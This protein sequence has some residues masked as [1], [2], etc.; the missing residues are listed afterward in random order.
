MN[1]NVTIIIPVYKDW[2]SLE[3]CISSLQK[4]VDRRHTVL[5]INDLSSE[6][7]KLEK[8]ILASIDGFTNFSYFRNN[9]NIGFL[10]TCNRG[11]YELDETTNDIL[12]L[13][14]DT[15]V[16]EGFLEEMLDI[17]YLHEKHGIVC[18]RSNNATILSIPFNYEGNRNQIIYKSYDYFNTLKNYL[19][20]FTTI[21]AGDGFC[22][23]IRRSLI[24]NFGLFDNIYDKG[25]NGVNDFCSRIN[26]FG[27]SAVMANHAFVYHFASRSF[28][29]E[30]IKRQNEKNEKIL[31]DSYPE[32]SFAVKRYLQQE[33]HPADYFSH[34]ICQVYPKKKI[35]FSLFNLSGGYDGTS[36]YGLSLLE[37]FLKLF[38]NKY[39]IKILINRRGAI[40]HGLDKLYSDILYYIEDFANSNEIFDLAIA[41]SQFF[42]INHLILLNRHALY[43]IFSLQDII[44]WRCNYLKDNKLD[45]ILMYS[46]IYSDGIIAISKFSKNDLLCYLENHRFFKNISIPIK[47]IYH[48]TKRKKELHGLKEEESKIIEDLAGERFIFLIGNRE[49]HKSIEVA[50][51]YL[52]DIP[53]KIVVLGINKNQLAKNILHDLPDNIMCLE[54]GKLSEDLVDF[55]YS[56]CDLI[57][58]PSQ[59][60]G[61]GLPII[62]A[63]LKK[64]KIVVFDN[65]INNELIERNIDFKDNIIKFKYYQDLKL[66][67]N[68]II[69]QSFIFESA[70][71]NFR[72][73]DDVAQETEQF[74]ADIIDRGVNIEKLEQRWIFFNYLQNIHDECHKRCWFGRQFFWTPNRIT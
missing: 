13:N 64:K 29:P 71:D 11:V 30:E 33:I 22:M 50:I 34:I 2:A 7:E 10:K 8:N 57:I 52:L 24:N 61:F 18:P 14:S 15:E 44:G 4:F 41:P 19:P 73:W 27:Y 66:I 45:F 5:I 59:Y 46:F 39:E 35:L 53:I 74:L 70:S 37:S 21:P 55:L 6:A 47:T 63:L 72:T 38:D 40:F 1:T 9:Q 20:R 3:K 28:S 32:Y 43:I 60:E 12:L 16:T 31:Q 56:K 69:N 68:N 25:Y 51:N 49:F 23:L 36:Q 67:V 58:Y 62:T 17:L 65:N 48:G 42:D 54:S 26:R